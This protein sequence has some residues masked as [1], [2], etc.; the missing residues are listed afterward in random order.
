MSGVAKAIREKLEAEGFEKDKKVEN[1]HAS[2]G[3][4]WDA[5]GGKKAGEAAPLQRKP[6]SAKSKVCCAIWGDLATKVSEM[7]HYLHA[8]LR[9]TLEL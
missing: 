1:G 8:C 2:A 4:A 7:Q 5:A 6:R 9:A 3:A